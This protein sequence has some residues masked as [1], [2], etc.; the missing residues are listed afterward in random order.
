M[1]TVKTPS[2]TDKVKTIRPPQNLHKSV[3][4]SCTQVDLYFSLRLQRQLQSL[5]TDSGKLGDELTHYDVS[6]CQCQYLHDTFAGLYNAQY[7]NSLHMYHKIAT[8][9]WLKKSVT[10]K[11]E[12]NPIVSIFHLNM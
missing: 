1:S 2:L 9:L 8:C 11:T 4:M 12:T 6:G 5:Q 10:D 3:N 7:G